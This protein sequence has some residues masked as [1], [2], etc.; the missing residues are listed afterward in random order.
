MSILYMVALLVL[1]VLGFTLLPAMSWFIRDSVP[2]GLGEFLVYG[3]LCLLHLSWG[4]SALVQR[5]FGYELVP[6]KAK[7]GR[8]G[9]KD[10]IEV[11]VDGDWV[12]INGSVAQ[13]DRYAFGL[14]TMLL[15]RGDHLVPYQAEG[16]DVASDGGTHQTASLDE[17]RQGYRAFDPTVLPDAKAASGNGPKIDLGLVSQSLKGA[18]AELLASAGRQK[19]YLEHG[20]IISRSG[21][22]VT[23]IGV[24]LCLTMGAATVWIGSAF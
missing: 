9:D 1:F 16:V 23:M 15:E 13:I 21:N 14:F 12:A 3:H 24:F 2:T 8:D 5:E 18:N 22:L 10:E 19:A 20:S 7:R 11:L 6:L 17:V 4:G